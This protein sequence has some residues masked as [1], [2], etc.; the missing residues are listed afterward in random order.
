[1]NSHLIFLSVLLSM[2][3]TQRIAIIGCGIGGSSQA[4]YLSQSIKN[5]EIHI[6]EENKF[7]GGRIKNYKINNNYTTELGAHYFILQNELIVNLIKDLNLTTHISKGD[8]DSIALWN[9]EKIFLE[10]GNWK[11]LNMLKMFWR[12]GFSMVKAKIA[13]NEH[14][15]LFLKFYTN[16]LGKNKKNKTKTYNSLHKILKGMKLL[17]LV[18]ITSEEFLHSFGFNNNFIDEFFQSI[19]SSIYNQGKDINAFAGFVTL[20]ALM[21]E[22][23]SIVGGNYNLIQ[24][25]INTTKSNLL[26]KLKIFHK[27]QVFE[28]ERNDDKLNLK[29]RNVNSTSNDFSTLSYD[30][31]IVAVPLSYSKIKFVN[32][33]KK[34][35][36]K[37][38][39]YK[40]TFISILA[41]DINFRAFGFKKLND[42][43]N[44]IL[45]NNSNTV[46]SELK[47]ICKDCYRVERNRVNVYSIQSS[48]NL[49]KFELD[50]LFSN[51][52][53][54][55]IQDWKY[56]YPIL[57]PVEIDDL[58]KFE[59][60][61]NVFNINVIEK[62]ASCMEMILI[63]SKNIANIINN[64]QKNINSE[65]KKSKKGK[66]K[67]KNKNDL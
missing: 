41:G 4:Y 21:N 25:L 6:F 27:V 54:V 34:I 52:S 14:L 48:H 58:P 64:R 38:S 44:V 47:T 51:Y 60:V 11:V 3:N 63:S 50:I 33:N 15:V 9:G 67:G 57:S 24:K 13:L 36:S 23:Y 55:H 31:V 28:I 2:I 37:T 39:V 29:F 53:I 42:V 19:I 10:L 30:I 40:N 12:Y 18:N 59:I 49:T 17:N 62:A 16:I 61:K 45:S 56:A 43:P 22:P 66:K 35:E 26:D 5:A 20:A 32:F 1:M 8:D 46:I 7:C 65:D